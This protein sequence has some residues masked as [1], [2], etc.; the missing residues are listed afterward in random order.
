MVPR[1]AMA[2]ECR[3][4]GPLARDKRCVRCVVRRVGV[5][6]G[7]LQRLVSNCSVLLLRKYDVVQAIRLVKRLDLPAHHELRPIL[8]HAILVRLPVRRAH[9]VVE[10]VARVGARQHPGRINHRIEIDAENLAVSQ[11]EELL[12]LLR[13]DSRLPRQL[14]RQARLPL[15]RKDRVCRIEVPRRLWSAG[16]R[17]SWVYRSGRTRISRVGRCRSRVR[18]RCPRV[19]PRP[20]ARTGS[21]RWCRRLERH[22]WNGAPRDAA[23]GRP[24]RRIA[25]PRNMRRRLLC[26]AFERCRFLKL[27]LRRLVVR[28]VGVEIDHQVVVRRLIVVRV[29]L[30][31]AHLH[32]VLGPRAGA[33]TGVGVGFPR[34]GILL[35]RPRDLFVHFWSL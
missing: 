1:V 20:G 4:F 19:H 29:V 30:R 26:R 32:V 7:R 14:H 34:G 8:L 3:P 6:H 27:P 35:Q 9:P 10:E 12:V 23:D 17:I 31:A 13:T 33:G 24:R 2:L 22:A 15:A 5:Q 21:R 25:E 28:R 16:P 18:R 11:R